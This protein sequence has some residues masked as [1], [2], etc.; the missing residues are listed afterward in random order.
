M[1]EEL[2]V[3]LQVDSEEGK[4]KLDEFATKLAAVT[5]GVVAVQDALAGDPKKD[6]TFGEPARKKVREYKRSV[7]EA[8]EKVRKFRSRREKKVKDNTFGG[9]AAKEV[10]ELSDAIDGVT[11]STK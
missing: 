8:D 4:F 6:A 1:A 7:G 2:E 5:A 11:Q 9:E 3:K 10:N